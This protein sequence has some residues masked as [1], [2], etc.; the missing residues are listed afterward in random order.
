M[1]DPENG[2]YLAFSGGKDSQA[3]YHI[4]KMAGVAFKP[5][6]SPTTVDP[7]QL[8]RFI[9]THYPDVEFE[10]VEKSMYKEAIEK[11]L[12]PTMRL[13]WCCAEF[14]E[15]AGAG[16][17]TL[18]G[19]RHGESARRS[20]RNEVEISR[21]KFSGNLDEFN[22]YREA[23]IRK[24]YK[25]INQDEFTRDK[26][27]EVRC[28][29][30]KDSITVAPIIEWTDRD[31]WEFLNE[32]VKVEHCCL[33][34]PPFN[35]HRIGCILCPMSSPKQKQRDIEL[36]PHVKQKWIEVIENLMGGGYTPL[37]REQSNPNVQG[38][39]GRDWMQGQF[40]TVPNLTAEDLFNWWISGE[41]F[42]VWYDKY[43]HPKLDL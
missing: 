11:G 1:Y 15:T 5:H 39:G 22:D 36:F 28:I 30:G 3:L 4:A 29:S 25:N 38:T 20:K 43:S 18:I 7:P 37:W 9:R 42:A 27:Q 17:V 32:V 40:G 8:I 19:I 10:K 6:F 12:L 26:E 23:H 13:R 31:V 14:K 21:H 16:K 33:Y 41:A 2:F 24:K 35:Q 34:D